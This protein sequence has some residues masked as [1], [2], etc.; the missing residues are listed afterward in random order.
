MTLHFRRELNGW[1]KD[2]ESIPDMRKK[3][4]FVRNDDSFPLVG[5][6]K[7]NKMIQLWFQADR[8]EG[9]WWYDIILFEIIE[10]KN[11]KP[12]LSD[13]GVCEAHFNLKEAK[14]FLYVWLMEH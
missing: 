3:S 10:E 9:I 4:E 6:R 14:A 12:L 8:K 2:L 13:T 1:I 7:G 11:G 5:Y